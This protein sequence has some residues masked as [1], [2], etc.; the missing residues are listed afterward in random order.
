VQRTKPKW[1]SL[2]SYNNEI[3]L[4]HLFLNVV[5]TYCIWWHSPSPLNKCK[6]TTSVWLV[7]TFNWDPQ[8]LFEYLT[9][10]RDPQTANATTL[11]SSLN[12]HVRHRANAPHQNAPNS[13]VFFIMYN[14]YYCGLNCTDTSESIMS[15]LVSSTGNGSL[16]VINI[17][18]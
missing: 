7:M 10:E 2:W 15:S 11:W 5:I 8:R 6:V 12:Y 14:I 16:H 4:C 18:K 17:V 13:P 1:L 9:D 3:C